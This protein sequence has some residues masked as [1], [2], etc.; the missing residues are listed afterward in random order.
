LWL[1]NFRDVAYDREANQVCSD[2]IADKIRR[3][4]KDQATA[5]KLIPRNHGFGTRRVPMETNYYEAYNQPNVRLV[6]VLETPIE[7]ITSIG[8]RTSEEDIEL[9]MLI[10]AT[11]F[12]AVTGAF[13]AI[14]IR[15]RDGKLLKDRWDGG[16]R[17]FVGMTVDGFPNMFMSMGPHQSYGNIPRSIEFAVNWITSALAYFRD[18]HITY[19]EAKPDGVEA[20]TEHVIDAAKGSLANEVD[21]WMTGINKNLPGK[22]KRIVNRYSGSAIGFRKFCNEVAAEDYRAFDLR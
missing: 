19:V 13:D 5:E 18:H 1:S 17:T 4:V 12:D 3:R 7:R 6:S 16:P 2:W 8:I 20:W 22:Q 11:G 15:G 9:D 14:D 10:Y 21:S